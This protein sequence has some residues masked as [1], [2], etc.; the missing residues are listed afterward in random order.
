MP[1]VSIKANSFFKPSFW[2]LFIPLRSS[3]R[4]R[5]KMHIELCNLSTDCLQIPADKSGHFVWVDQPDVIVD[6]VKLILNKVDSAG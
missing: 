4:L 3:N 5:D 1:I 2:T 6:S